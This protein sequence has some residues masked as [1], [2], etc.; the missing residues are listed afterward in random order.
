MG[1]YIDRKAYL[2][3][4]R[5]F[6]LSES[7]IIGEFTDWLPQDIIDCH[8]H[9]NLPAHVGQMS[10][11]AYNHM[12]STFPSFTLQESEE[13]N[14]LFHPGKSIRT[15][16]FALPFKGI[17]HKSANLYLL[18]GSP[19]EDRVALCGLPDD[20][21]YTIGMLA[22]KKTL[23]LKMYYAHLE[24]WATEIYQYFTKDILAVAEARNVPI[25]LHLPDQITACLGQLLR[26]IEDFPRLKICIAHL[27]LVEYSE[28]GL[29]GIFR[30]VQKYPQV[31]LDTA[32]VHSVEV[33]ALAIGVFGTHR[34]MYGSD[35][36]LHLARYAGYKN[37]QLGNRIVSEYPYHWA[38]PKEH[39][40]F[41]HLAK[42]VTHIHWRALSALKE[43]IIQL[44]VRQRESAK[45]QIFYDNAQSLYG[46]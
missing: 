41:K 31:F 43:A 35:A 6:T 46:F 5:E 20:P 26:L 24:P 32:L 40:R 23:A 10:N 8:A 34:I 12:F 42:G 18:E 11:L 38:N 29:E 22:H 27:G 15:L 14:K 17:N 28:P 37:P 45:R 25:V 30:E 16:R 36:P 13:W 3:Y 33:I 21:D 19:V 4:A 1:N 9:C 44:P 7:K 39:D 2:A